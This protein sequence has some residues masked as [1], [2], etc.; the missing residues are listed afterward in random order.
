MKWPPATCGLSFNAFSK[1]AFR[2][3]NLCGFFSPLPLGVMLTGEVGA[4]SP[5]PVTESKSWSELNP[6]YVAGQQLAGNWLLHQKAGVRAGRW[7]PGA[8]EV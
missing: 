6:S 3:L 7:A 1:K 5:H 4:H 2:L 8:L